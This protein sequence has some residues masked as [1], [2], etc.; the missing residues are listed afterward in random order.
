M[1]S[2]K[3]L[4]GTHTYEVS[5]KELETINWVFGIENKIVNTTTNNDSNFVKAFKVP[6]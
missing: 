4:K 3:R 2:C 1:L 5:A 6:H